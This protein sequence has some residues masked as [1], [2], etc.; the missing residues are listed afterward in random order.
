MARAIAAGTGD[1]RPL[2]PIGISAAPKLKAAV[3]SLSQKASSIGR[4]LGPTARRMSLG[5]LRARNGSNRRSISSQSSKSRKKTRTAAISLILCVAPPGSPGRRTRHS[6]AASSPRRR[7]VTYLTQSCAVSIVHPTG[8]VIV[9]WHLASQRPARFSEC[10]TDER[11]DCERVDAASQRLHQPSHS[12]GTPAGPPIARGLEG[13]SIRRES[14]PSST[15][16]AETPRSMRRP[17]RDGGLCA[18]RPMLSSVTTS[19]VGAPCQ[20]RSSATVRGIAYWPGACRYP[21]RAIAE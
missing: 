20:M 5:T 10:E 7:S 9:G 18:K 8:D 17:A 1:V 14:I 12:A 3:R 2:P 13:P 21:K 4:G 19:S 15:R 16:P 11:L 6:S